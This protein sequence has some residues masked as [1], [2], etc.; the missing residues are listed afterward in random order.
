M[1]L[2]TH[3]PTDADRYRWLMMNADVSGYDSFTDTDTDSADAAD[4]P[5]ISVL[6]IMGP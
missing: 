1:N 4:G 3:L 2:R 6:S 5:S